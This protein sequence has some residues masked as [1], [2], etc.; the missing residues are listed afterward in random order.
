M[1]T[2][3]LLADRYEVGGK[4]GS[5]GMAEVREG[6]D[7]RL[8]RPI[9]IKLLHPAV[10]AQSGMRNRFD[11]EACAAAAL[12]HPNIVAVYD[13]GEQDGQPFIVMERLPGETLAHE[14]ARGPL[15]QLRVRV[16]LDNVLAALSAAHGAAILHRDIKPGNILIA[17]GGEIVKVA[18]FGIAKLPEATN[19]LTGQI[20][21]TIAYLSPERIAGAPACVADD[22]YALGVVGYEALAGHRPFPQENM[23]ALAGAILHGRPPPLAGL[24]PDVDP[25][26]IMVIERAMAHDP[27][28]RFGSADEMRAAL[29]GRLDV[30]AGV[31]AA[32]RRHPATKPL[33]VPVPN[34]PT[35]TFVPALVPP[36]SRRRKLLGVLAVL[37]VLIL[38]PLGLA[39]DASSSHAPVEPATTATPSP[40]PVSNAP[41]PTPSPPAPQPVAPPWHGPGKGHGKGNGGG[42]GD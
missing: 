18:D 17:A 10:C 1:N 25:R 31:R 13:S 9:A 21:G 14:L 16:L 42:H 19:T 20:L 23:A 12:N 6:W 34:S 27:G 37:A 11:A 29:H 39:L 26:L 7:T 41:P 2:R 35:N 40:V 30:A 4:L 33:E 15:A 36:T 24:R 28:R 8:R 32:P 3:V 5:G 38:I 22:L